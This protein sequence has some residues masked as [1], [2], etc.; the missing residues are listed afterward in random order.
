MVKLPED[1]T[2]FTMI[3]DHLDGINRTVVAQDAD[4]D[5][6]Q[7]LIESQLNDLDYYKPGVSLHRGM[8]IK[9]IDMTQYDTK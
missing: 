9:V 8:Q 7:D 6:K 4:N 2:S 1:L 5:K 3:K